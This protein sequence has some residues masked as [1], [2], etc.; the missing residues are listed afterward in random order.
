MGQK[1]DNH[2]LIIGDSGDLMDSVGKHLKAAGFATTTTTGGNEGLRRLYDGSPDLVIVAQPMAHEDGLALCAQVRTE[3]T[4]PLIVVTGRGT[5]NDCVEALGA[6]ADDFIAKPFTARV[7]EARIY[8][9]IRRSNAAP[10]RADPSASG[11]PPQAHGLLAVGDIRL[12]LTTCR[13]SV[14]GAVRTLTPNEFRLMAI[15]LRAPGEV[16]TREDLRRRVWP[17]DLHSLHLVEVHIA[18]LRA[19]I[20][21]DPHHPTHIV[22]VRS[23]GYRLALP[24]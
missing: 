21:Q 8:A 14:G 1:N 13:V 24:A 23:R 2:V 22:T 7:L 15:F 20:E 18:N 10:Y 9:A 12:D 5:E 11:A 4:V 6:G 19:K 16:F 3:S 17:D